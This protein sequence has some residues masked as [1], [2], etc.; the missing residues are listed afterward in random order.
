MQTLILINPVATPPRAESLASDG[1]TTE[2]PD[3]SFA[4]LLAGIADGLPAKEPI[5]TVAVAIAVPPETVLPFR[6]EP[7]GAIQGLAEAAVMP[8]DA[9]EGDL[10]RRDILVAGARLPEV[11]IA[12][13]IPGVVVRPS[14][15]VDLAPAAAMG[16]S[17]P[18]RLPEDAAHLLPAPENQGLAPP[19]LPDLRPSTASASNLLHLPAV[20]GGTLPVAWTFLNTLPDRPAG[21]AAGPIKS[22]T[23]AINL[24]P[25]PSAEIPA[26][27]ASQISARNL[28]DRNLLAASAPNLLPAPAIT[29]DPLH[30]ARIAFVNLPDET[31][32]QAA[33]PVRSST[34]AVNLQP[35]P[36]AEISAY[37]AS[38]LADKADPANAHP[39]ES[40]IASAMAKLAIPSIQTLAPA[41]VSGAAL[42]WQ[43][44]LMAGGD[45]SEPAEQT[46]GTD[47]VPATADIRDP[48]AAPFRPEG[49]VAPTFRWGDGLGPAFPALAELDDLELEAGAIPASGAL[50]PHSSTLGGTLHPS[51]PVSLQDL[52]RLAAQLAGTLVHHADGQTDVALS[53]EELGH[54]RLSLQADAQNPDRMVVMLTFERPETLDLFRRHADQLADALREAGYSGADISFGT[55]GGEN[56]G[57]EADRDRS[58]PVPQDAAPLDRDFT[59]LHHPSKPAAAGS[60]DLRL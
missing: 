6:F 40:V 57:D 45:Q 42:F 2:A 10:P 59:P 9:S 23:L 50:P 56:A 47:P 28:P 38:Q 55:S 49:Q 34:L 39:V 11:P 15:S 24:Q 44:G 18:I 37:G 51:A 58:A 54:V 5:E 32:A 33:G 3:E 1:A 46:P 4:D 12:G 14:Q 60:L 31:T 53:P 16:I 41:T 30:M 27:V 35:P 52:P 48:S 36:P 19:N 13:I 22:S 20:A 21:E 8:K 25:P 26:D 17:L 7:M 29:A 43:A